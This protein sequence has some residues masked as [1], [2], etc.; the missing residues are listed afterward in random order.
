M[1]AGKAARRAAAEQELQAA[2]KAVYRPGG[3]GKAMGRAINDRL[4]AAGFPP[5]SQTVIWR[6]LRQFKAKEKRD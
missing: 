2:L 6:R 1:R 5:V 4:I 3:L